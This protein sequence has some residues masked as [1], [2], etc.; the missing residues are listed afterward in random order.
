MKKKMISLILTAALL[1]ITA[2]CGNTGT[3][4]GGQTDGAQPPAAESTTQSAA[5]TQ[6]EA[7]TQDSVA[8]PDAQADGATQAQA[9]A[10]SE[11]AA[12]DTSGATEGEESSSNVLVAYFSWA[13]NTVLDEDVD[14]VSSPSVTAPGNVQEL[15]GWVQE[16]TGGDLFSI[17]VTDPYPSDWDECLDRA[18]EERGEDA[19]PQLQE[20]VENLDDYDTVF[21]GYP[22]WW[23]GV[24]M[25][26]LSFLE[27]NDLSGKQVYLFCSHGTG[28][29]A[30]SVDIIE[31]AAPDAEISDN[32][33]DC[34]EEDASSSQGE[35][36]SWVEELGY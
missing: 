21:L 28:G 31:E 35:I 27:E 2:G 33:F 20:N 9:E 24:P 25:A 14:A 19:R 29:L 17:R 1:T 6:A 36:Q 11:A 30:D 4:S 7:D 26:L 22:N 15:A 3:Q 16:E 12:G 5:D 34:Y 23:Y 13:D 8:Q 18:N 10:Q 32:I